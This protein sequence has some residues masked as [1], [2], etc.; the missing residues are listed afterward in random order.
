MK[1]LVLHWSIT[2]Q[3]KRPDWILRIFTFNNKNTLYLPI[4]STL[5]FFLGQWSRSNPISDK[6]IWNIPNIQN[7]GFK[8]NKNGRFF[9]TSFYFSLFFLD[10]TS[11]TFWD[12]FLSPHDQICLQVSETVFCT[13]YVRYW[14]FLKQ[15]HEKL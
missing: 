15:L 4:I 1:L 14:G 7:S 9:H 3:E 8:R 13:I 11:H 6:T 5:K 10:N 12:Q 2:W